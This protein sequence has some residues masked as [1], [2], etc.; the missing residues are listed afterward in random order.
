M[1]FKA[2]I[3][4]MD[5]VLI[6]SEPLHKEIEQQMLKELGVELSH[7]E[8][9]KFAGVGK[10]MWTMLGT[11]YGYNREVGEDELHEEKRRRYLKALTSAP[12][13]P[14]D[15]VVELVSYVKNEKLK[16]A[17]AS[18]SS[19]ENIDLITKSIGI[20]GDMEVLVSGDDTEKTK[21]SP[22]IF[23]LAAK[24]LGVPASECLVIEDSCNGVTA[25]KRAGMYCVGF[26]NP[27]SGMQDLT[28]ADVVLD[29]IIDVKGVLN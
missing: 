7:E 11:Q 27:N 5:G 6:D 22:D 19:H 12:I 17:V 10:E 18:S 24:L 25:A 16:M 8:H 2:V 9:I 29:R 1:N 13:R 21:P 23:L 4:D 3:F 20:H 28:L 26:R 14:I 15:G